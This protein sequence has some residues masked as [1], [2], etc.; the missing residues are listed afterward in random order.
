MCPL[1]IIHAIQTMVVEEVL[2]LSIMPVPC[3]DIPS[4]QIF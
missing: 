1:Q 3:V 4:K 2:R